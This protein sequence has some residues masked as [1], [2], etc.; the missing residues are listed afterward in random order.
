ML[1]PAI[2]FVFLQGPQSLIKNFNLRAWVE[3]LYLSRISTRIMRQ[4]KTLRVTQIQ[5]GSTLLIQ[6]D[7][8]SQR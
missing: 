8:G 5:M 6:D 1:F 3:S 7:F 2:C 4:G